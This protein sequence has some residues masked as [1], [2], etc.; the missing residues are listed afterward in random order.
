MLFLLLLCLLAAGMYFLDDNGKRIHVPRNDIINGIS[1]EAPQRIIEKQELVSAKEIHANW[2]ALMPFAFSR[3]KDP[4]LVFDRPRQW[5]GERA[6]GIRATINYAH[7]LG[8]KVMIKPHVWVRG[9]GWPGEFDLGNE[10]D[11]IAWEKNYREYVLHYAKLADSLDVTMFCIGTEFR[12]AAV[13]R[14][15]FWRNLILEIR[16]F[17]NGKL[18]YAANWD[19]YQ[20][21]TFWHELDYIGI[22]AYFPISEERTPSTEGLI[23]NWEPVK[24]Q[25]QDFSNRYGKPLLFTEYGY[26]SIDYAV[27]GDWVLELDTVA[28]NYKAQANGYEAI[29]RVFWNESWFAGGFLWKWHARPDELRGGSGKRFTPQGKI[30]EQV[31]RTWYGE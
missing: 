29:Y 25:L 27:G 9:Q 23:R 24:E 13:K 19:N 3:E 11:W 16:S 1:F 28:V 6:E 21:I 10:E 30:A 31:I 4:Q 5:W 8:L 7:D 12:K 15:L 14:P 22:D 20:N 2:V 17:Y 18:T 26:R